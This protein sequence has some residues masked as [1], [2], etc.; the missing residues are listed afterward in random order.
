M[1]SNQPD[2]NDFLKRS[3][4]MDARP[5]TSAVAAKT[6]LLGFA[7]FVVAIFLMN[8]RLASS[9]VRGQDERLFENTIP[10]D[11]PIKVKIKKEKEQ[12]FKDLKNEKWVREFELEVT[13]AGDK[14]IYFL[15]LDMITDVKLGGDPL[16]FSLVYGRADLGDIISKARSEDIPIKAGETYVFKIHPGQVPAWEQSVHEARHPQASRIRLKIESLSFGDGTGYFGNHPYPPAG[17]RQSA[18][19]NHIQRPNKS[20]LKSF[21]LTG[22]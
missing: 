2:R 6:L 19:E 4:L 15:F 12:S 13:N 16:V 10:K 9:I 17:K 3:D 22:L 20:G 11:V 18:L 21:S 5:K 14:P 7:L 8:A 1:P